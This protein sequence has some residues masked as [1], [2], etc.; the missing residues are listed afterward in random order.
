MGGVAGALG[1]GLV[2]GLWAKPDFGDDGRARQTP[3]ARTASVPTAADLAPAVPLPPPDQMTI[4]VQPQV[5]APTEAQRREMADRIEVLPPRAAPAPRPAPPAARAAPAPQIATAPPPVR[6]APPAQ[7]VVPPAPPPTQSASADE[8]A[9]PSFPCRFARSRSERMVCADAGLASADRRLAR[10][11]NR[12]VAAGVPAR[13]LRSDQDDWLS[14]REDAA[15][16]GPQA[17][18]NVYEQ[19]IRELNEMADLR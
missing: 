10:A 5:Q 8:S 13:E 16:Y 12:A 11:Y 7:V 9:R 4:E 2:F 14:I 15:R 6:I 19:R 18:G 1:L 17:V 3:P